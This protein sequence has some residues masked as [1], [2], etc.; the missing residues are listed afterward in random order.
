MVVT[1]QWS[2]NKLEFVQ[3]VYEK[4]LG[5]PSNVGAQVFTILPVSQKSE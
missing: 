4:N 5:S 3:E 2:T 1:E